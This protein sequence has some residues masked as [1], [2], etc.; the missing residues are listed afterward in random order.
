MIYIFKEGGEKLMKE[1]KI[2]LFFLV[3]TF[4]V[5]HIVHSEESKKLRLQY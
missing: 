1:L 5:I 2:I 4:F 3:L